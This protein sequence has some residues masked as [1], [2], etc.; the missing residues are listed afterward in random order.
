M[1]IVH[2]IGTLNIGGAEKLLK[3]LLPK[4]KE[5]GNEIHLLVIGSANKIFIEYLVK[6]EVSVVLLGKSNIYN[7]IN[8]FSINKIIKKFKYIHVHLF[9]ALYFM[10]VIKFFYPQKI[11]FY[12]EHSTSNKRRDKKYFKYLEKIIYESYSKII[13]ISKDTELNLLEWLSFENDMGRFCTIGNG[14]NIEEYSSAKPLPMD[15]YINKRVILMVSRFSE[16]KDHETLIKAF[17]IVA[18]KRRDVVLL[19][20]GE[21]KTLIDMRKIVEEHS[22]SN[23]VHFLG[24]RNDIPNLM[25]LSDIGVQSSNWEGF[26]LTAVEFM[27]SGTP[28]IGTDVKGLSEVVKNGGLLFKHGDYNDLAE[29]ILKLLDDEHFYRGVSKKGKNK[30]QL[31]S[32]EKMANS[33]IEVYKEFI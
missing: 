18:N 30:S 4:L 5:K 28:F 23:I 32:C 19:F 3:D 31:Y 26:G 27:A 12:T 7:P 1:E 15:D 22:L 29:L 2:V 14:I 6:N 21:G 16:Q 33:Y 17:R 11:F 20:A 25:A 10:S 24:N 13:S 8:I 9:P